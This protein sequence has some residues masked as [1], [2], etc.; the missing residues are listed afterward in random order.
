MKDLYLK[1]LVSTMENS[2]LLSGMYFSNCCKPRF[3]LTLLKYKGA[4]LVLIWS[5]LEISVY[6]YY[7]MSATRNPIKRKSYLP[8]NPSEILAA[9]I[10]LPVGGWLADAY[11]GRYKVI[12]CGMWTMWLGA[13]LNGVSLVIGMVVAPYR[14]HGDPW[15]SLICRVVLGAGFGAF[16][17]NII[18]FGIDQLSEA[19]STE[20]TSFI[21]WYTLTIFACGVTMQ[22]ITSC[23]PHYVIVLVLAVHL[24][25]ALGSNYI[26]SHWLDKEQKILNSFPLIRKT[27]QYSIKHRNKWKRLFMLGHRGVLS[28]LNVAKTMYG[29]PFTSEQV[30]D[31]KTF[32]RVLAVIAIFLTVFSGIPTTMYTADQLEPRFHHRS[33]IRVCYKEL[34]IRYAQYIVLVFVVLVYQ[35]IIH[36]ICHKCI[37]KVSITTK[38]F[39]AVLL[40]F[41][42]VMILLG[43]ESTSYH[44]QLELNQ[45]IIKCG[46]HSKSSYQDIQSYLVIIPQ[47]MT[48]LSSF[49]LL[50]AGIEFICAQAPFNMKGLLFG[51][52]YALYGLGSLVQSALSTPFLH[53]H[54]AWDKAPLTCGIWYF[55]IQGVIV[56]VGFIVVIIM[57]KTYKRRIRINIPQLRGTQIESVNQY[58]Q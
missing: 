32:F 13:M 2:V 54:S 24:T 20:I 4:I 51:I 43:M 53:N 55:I 38:F 39:I 23:Q 46:F 26:L 22:F 34:S 11:F 36:P 12:L 47:T 18:Q 9:G 56:L 8:L 40:F 45:T 10:F 6:H 33:Q 27:V 48:A 14:E 15:V 42:G 16:Q 17:V 58:T 21:S 7:A 30:E 52:G 31:V 25:M 37:P 41:A 1:D 49:L 3:Q 44:K 29:G 50:S 35:T 5:F 28:K 57:I 19:S